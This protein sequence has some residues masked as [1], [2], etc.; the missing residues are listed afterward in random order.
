MKKW[1]TKTFLF[2]LLLTPALLLPFAASADLLIYDVDKPVQ[3][4]DSPKPRG[5][6]QVATSTPKEKV[7][8][9]RN[10]FEKIALI[11]EEKTTEN[12]KNN[13]NQESRVAYLIAGGVI[14]VGA[15]GA[16]I[17]LFK[18]KRE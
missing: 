10:F 2:F 18:S 9:N 6:E 17:I 3:P 8:N 16:L 4:T 11:G 15:A 7:R 12:T 13:A 1:L 14:L 5:E